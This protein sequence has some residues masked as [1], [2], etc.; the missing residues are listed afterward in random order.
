MLIKGAA[1]PTI[2][3]FALNISLKHLAQKHIE[4]N[5]ARQQLITGNMGVSY[6]YI[7]TQQ[8]EQSDKLLKASSRRIKADFDRGNLLKI[9]VD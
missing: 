3:H 7:S 9:R 1:I 8:A 5:A 4:A 6:Q 2:F